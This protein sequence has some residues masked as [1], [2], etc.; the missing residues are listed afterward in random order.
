M[1]RMFECPADQLAALETEVEDNNG[2]GFHTSYVQDVG[3]NC[4]GKWSIT[5]PMYFSLSC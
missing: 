2:I 3:R 4:L 1:A 5:T